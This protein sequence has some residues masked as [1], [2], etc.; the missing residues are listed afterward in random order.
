MAVPSFD[1]T[2]RTALVTGARRGIGQA[3]AVALAAHGA[4]IIGAS[5]SQ[6]ADGSD[7]ERLVETQGRSFVG[8]ACDFSNRD[9][10][11]DFLS[12]LRAE[13]PPIDILV[14]NAGMAR[15]SAAADHTDSAWDAVIEVNLTAPFILTRELAAP[16]LARGRGK[17]IFTSSILGFSGGTGIVSYTATKTALVG[18]VKAL[19]NEW[20][21]HGVNI[22][23]IA[24]GYVATDIT[25]GLQDDAEAS[26]AIVRRIPAGRWGTPDDIAG[27]ALFLASD[28]S[29]YVN[30][31][32]IVVDGGWLGR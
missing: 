19:A 25:Q 10:T 21:R 4:D 31:T 12:W 28:A 18:L 8:R 20:A 5:A 13:Q 14:N 1:L 23:A 15:S 17:I 26:R 16:M 3:I 7:V 24:P 11:H 30:G 2:G 6:E 29:D 32:V 9:A 27:A 22:N